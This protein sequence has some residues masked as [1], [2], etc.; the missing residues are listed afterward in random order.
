MFI[1]LKK[2]LYAVFLIALSGFAGPKK[3]LTLDKETKQKICN[4]A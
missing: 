3:F 4:R 2:I 1:K